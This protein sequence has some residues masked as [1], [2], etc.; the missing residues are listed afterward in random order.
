MS[1]PTLFS[2]QLIRTVLTEEGTDKPLA[3]VIIEMI[4]VG[5]WLN[6]G[7]EVVEPLRDDGMGGV[8]WNPDAVTYV[9]GGL[10]AVGQTDKNGVVDWVLYEGGA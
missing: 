10:Y 2:D 4:V 8:E 3:N 5:Y 1:D 7:S 6:A 9:P